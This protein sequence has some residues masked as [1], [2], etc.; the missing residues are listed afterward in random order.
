MNSIGNAAWSLAVAGATF[1]RIG[2]SQTEWDILHETETS[3]LSVSIVLHGNTS[4]FYRTKPSPCVDRV[5]LAQHLLLH[6]LSR[7][8]SYD[9]Y[10]F[11]RFNPLNKVLSQCNVGWV[12]AFRYPKFNCEC[13]E[14]NQLVISPRAYKRTHFP[15]HLRRFERNDRV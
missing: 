13:N 8:N 9:L 3:D 11:T 10:L 5:V 1:Q 12:L 2:W 14:Y 7:I 4:L 6:V 15:R